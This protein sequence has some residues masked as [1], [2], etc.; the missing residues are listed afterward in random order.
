MGDDSDPGLP[1]RHGADSLRGR[2]DTRVSLLLLQVCHRLVRVAAGY[3]PVHVCLGIS[4]PWI[5][6]IRSGKIDRQKRDLCAGHSFCAASSG[7][8]IFGNAGLHPRRLWVW[9]RGIQNKVVSALFYHT[10]RHVHN[11][12]LLCELK[13]GQLYFSPSVR[14]PLARLETSLDSAAPEY[15]TGVYPVPPGCHSWGKKRELTPFMGSKG[16]QTRGTL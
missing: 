12:G 14:M 13:W 9:L 5:H 15:T 11:D 1:C 10:L 2:Q 16:A 4:V 3:R 8:A 6:A 7:E